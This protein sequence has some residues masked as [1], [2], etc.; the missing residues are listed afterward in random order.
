MPALNLDYIAGGRFNWPG[1]LVLAIGVTVLFLSIWHYRALSTEIYSHEV[2]VSRLQERVNGGP[3]SPGAEMRDAE[4][5]AREIRQAN[6]A[7]LALS[8]PWKDLFDAFEA[9]RAKDVAVLA[10]EPDAQKGIVRITAEGRN[11]ESMLNYI[12]S[13]QKIALFREVVILNHQIQERDPQKP[14]RFVAQAAWEMKR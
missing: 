10:I 2:L 5:I 9:N 12:S 8:L 7:I 14:V 11:F 6:A 3:V 1:M 4:Q 13:L